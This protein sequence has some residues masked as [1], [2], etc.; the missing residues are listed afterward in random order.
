M[1]SVFRTGMLT[2]E[3]SITAMT[4]FDLSFGREVQ[5]N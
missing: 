1:R 3:T 5:R 4:V 2:G